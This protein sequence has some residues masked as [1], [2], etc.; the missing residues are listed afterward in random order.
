MNIIT[1][2]NHVY[3]LLSSNG[4]DIKKAVKVQEDNAY[5]LL[6][7]NVQEQRETQYNKVQN[8]VCTMDI[9]CTS[10]DST[11]CDSIITQ[12][13]NVIE[14]TIWVIDGINISSVNIIGSTEEIDPLSGINT[15]MLTVQIN[16]ITRART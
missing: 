5:I 3:D 13:A 12:V 16:Y 1:I 15:I 11:E 7:T 2:K 4:L 10:R 8:A 6:I 14:S 9:S